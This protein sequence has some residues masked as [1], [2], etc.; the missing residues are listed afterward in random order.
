[1]MKAAVVTAAGKTPIY[2]D[3][4]K[5][6]AK[7]GEEIISVRAAALSNLTKARASGADYSAAH[8]FPAVAGTDGVGRTQNGRRVYFAMPEPPYGSLAEYCPIHPRR[9]VDI[10]DSLDD[11]T[12]AAIANPGMSAWWTRGARTSCGRGN[13]SGQRRDRNCRQDRRAAGQAPGGGQGNRDRQERE[14]T[15]RIEGPRGR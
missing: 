10:P 12:A 13:G 14:R 2:A 6:A 3:F 7:D 5:P 9:S 1:M 8:I 4:E 11:I 15:G